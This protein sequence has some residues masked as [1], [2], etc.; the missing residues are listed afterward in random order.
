MEPNS[1]S[2]AAGAV[3]T[4]QA[5]DAK[6]D[7]LSVEKPG[8]R[9]WWAALR[10]I[11]S[12]RRARWIALVYAVFAI[13]WI[14]FSDHLLNL[15]VSDSALLLRWSIYKGVAYVLVT[16]LL[17]LILMQ[18]A[19]GA[20]EAAYASLRA[21][22]QQLLSNAQQLSGIISSAS[23]AIVS[24]DSSGR[25]V[26]FNRAAE[27][28]FRW[29][30]DAILGKEVKQC[31]PEFNWRE[32]A[33]HANAIQLD[34]VRRDGRHLV[35]EGSVSHLGSGSS[36]M[37]T[38]ILR[39]ISDQLAHV[40]EV[41]RLQRLLEA[42]S[43]INQ[44]IV[45]LPV[46]EE[47][48]AHICRILVENGGFR[49][50]WIG[51]PDAASGLLRPVAQFGDTLS[52][53][54]DISISF[55]DVPE[56]R[57][58]TGTAF[59]T[60]RPYICNDIENDPVTL[61]WR[62][63]ATQ[64]G[65]RALAAFPIRRKGEVHGVMSVY[66]A[67]SL[68]FQDREIALLSEAALDISFAL[69]N[70]ARESERR[71]ADARASSEQRFSEAMIDSMPGV[72][73]FYDMRGRFLRWNRNFERVSGYSPAEIANMHPSEFFAPEDRPALEQR[74]TEVFISG[75]SA[76]EANFLARDGSSTPYFF[77][78]KR[79]LFEGI[80]CLVG[81]GIDMTE[82]R[83]V[84]RQLRQARDELESKVVER[85]AELQTALVRAESADRL[86]SA[87]L[88]TMSHELRT[89][90][91]S[92]IGFTGIVIQQMAGPLNDE[93]QRQLG[94]VRSSAR[95][96]LA[97][98]ND[99]LDFSKIEAGQLV[100]QPLPLELNPVIAHTVEVVRPLA[101]KQGL[102][103]KLIIPE[104]PIHMVSDQRRIEQILLNLLNNA[105]KFTESG[106]VTLSVTCVADYVPPAGNAVA[107]SLSD[108]PAVPGVPAVPAV[109][110]EVRDSGIG[111]QAE[112]IVALFR[113]FHQIDTGLARQREGTG[114]GLVISRRLV[115]LLGGDI[116][117][118]SQPEQGSTFTVTLPLQMAS[119]A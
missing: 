8:W 24:L 18:R 6:L 37:R 62:H 13:L 99:V 1:D 86:K 60:G 9:A 20:V 56:G 91:N 52:Y 15:L 75:E 106:S 110:L 70:L 35:L 90:L 88:A 17:L 10:H 85:T 77:T 76:L 118:T 109:C 5:G 84:E 87:F 31:L 19:F 49:M 43:H 36:P 107:S 38:L 40:H 69:D 82:Q 25:V 92:I 54:S 32:A 89:P 44:A 95:H 22:Q 93:Q 79:V 98:I 67:E 111:I 39:N 47:L 34:G 28:M 105:I 11:G 41:E 74:I 96:L 119:A 7:T 101:Q 29:P 68:F 57:G 23:D 51:C 65:Y 14:Y 100:I 112:D 114:L 53:L 45:R 73:Y 115:T 81:I 103:L 12:S 102:E 63:K 58:P 71:E 80:T 21:H 78:G 50:A 3:S 94:M 97:L 55:S 33:P 16:S 2:A 42:L 61:A 59:R 4:T 48:F 26:L 30:A 27:T 116:S 64:R 108:A 72:V 104:E 66:A 46:R 117:V 83:A 113:P